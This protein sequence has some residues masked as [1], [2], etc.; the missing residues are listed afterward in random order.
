MTAGEGTAKARPTRAPRVGRGSRLGLGVLC[1]M[2]PAAVAQ[3]ET[4]TALGQEGASSALHLWFLLST[5]TAAFA[6]TL[7]LGLRIRAAV[8]PARRRLAR[9]YAGPGGPYAGLRRLGRAAAQALF[10]LSLKLLPAGDRGRDRV[11]RRLALAGLR[12][13]GTLPAYYAARALLAGTLL[14]LAL[15]G[16]LLW[17]ALAG[18]RSLVLAAFAVYI[19][20]VLPSFALDRLIEQRRRRLREA[21]PDTLDMLVLCVEAGLSLNVAIGRIAE[22]IRLAHPD[23]AAELARLASELR[24]GMP[25]EQALEAL[26]TRTGLEDVGALVKLLSQSLRYGTSVAY[27]LRVFADDYRDR[28]FRL[29]EERGATL[30][31]RLVFPLLLC[32]FPAFFV[33][34]LGPALL[35]FAEIFHVLGERGGP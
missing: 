21:F 16:A 4:A 14:P 30:G 5:A 27:A 6:I 17:P 11:V 7:A 23:M 22:H 25:R 2:V 31:T 15:L 32:L 35:R 8:D 26:A 3:T 20:F 19:G 24:L 33:V 29:A 28:R 34:A 12:G 9:L 1:L 18:P 10:K 13:P